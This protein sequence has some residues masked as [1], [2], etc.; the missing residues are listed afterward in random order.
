MPEVTENFVRI[1]V[2][3][4]SEFEDGTMGTMTLNQ[5]SGVRAVVGRL[6]SNGATVIASYLFEIGKDEWTEER[7]RGWVKG[8]ED[9]YQTRAFRTRAA[10]Y[11]GDADLRVIMDGATFRL[12]EPSEWE[13]FVGS[14]DPEAFKTAD[15]QRFDHVEL[16]ENG[17]PTAFRIVEFG[18]WQTSK[19]GTLKVSETAAKG[20]MAWWAYKW[21][22]ERIPMDWGHKSA[23]GE[24]ERSPGYWKPEIREDGIWAV[25]V[26]WTP[27]GYEQLQ[28]KEIKFFSP[29]GKLNAKTKE[30]LAVTYIA[31]TN[32]PATN[33][34]K[35]LVASESNQAGEDTDA[36]ISGDEERIIMQDL[37]KKLGLPEDAT[38]EQAIAKVDELTKA[39]PE[40]TETAHRE[41]IEAKD[42]EIKALK[43]KADEKAGEFKA[44]TLKACGLDDDADFSKVLAYVETLKA[45]AP[46]ADKV[47]KL[48]A[49]A[50]EFDAFREDIRVKDI[51]ASVSAKITPANRETV[52]RLARALDAETFTATMKDWPDVKG[53]NPDPAKGS[54]VDKRNEDILAHDSLTDDD[55]AFFASKGWDPK[56]DEGKSEIKAYIAAK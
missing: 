4:P 29:E 27:K 43:A 20:T 34:Q 25:D 14:V 9:R 55:R 31:L 17:V 39:V 37:L 38:E 53:A 7:A 8:N 12:E 2:R 21:G 48:E 42:K 35:P 49:K 26:E 28:N 1:P 47:A 23:S 18:D 13:R 50:A 5:K 24:D 46:E 36:T 33:H 54:T 15:Q 41:A 45:K 40:E 3:K 51:L 32:R 6:K 56:T 11:T 22:D 44:E 30:V 52:E 16:D 10:G 19:Y